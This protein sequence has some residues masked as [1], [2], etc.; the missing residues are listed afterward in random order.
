MKNILLLIILISNYV[1]AQEYVP[2]PDVVKSEAVNRSIN[3]SG[4]NITHVWRVIDL[5]DT[6]NK[7]LNH[8]VKNDVVSDIYS[9]MLLHG[10]VENN[11]LQF[12]I[13]D[14]ASKL[15]PDDIHDLRVANFSIDMV[16]LYEQYHFDRQIGRMVVEIIAI[17]PV[18]NKTDKEYQP[19]F[20]MPYEEF[21]NSVA[22]CYV[23]QTVRNK[24]K[25]I[26][27]VE[28]FDGRSFTSKK[29]KVKTSY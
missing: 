25:T 2:K 22:N 13:H 6:I 4:S 12:S 28:L 21:K 10:R 27:V 20:W 3:I 1:S 8:M 11:L 17:A 26:S 29:I 16:M 18:I 15:S 9:F 7:G 24:V 14:T 5:N 23:R 19:L